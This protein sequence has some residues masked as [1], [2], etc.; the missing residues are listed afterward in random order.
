MQDTLSE[1]A[2]GATV[3]FPGREYTNLVLI[4]SHVT[5]EFNKRLPNI[6]RLRN[7]EYSDWLLIEP[8]PEVLS[9]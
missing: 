1:M 9:T 3:P 5:V 8:S 4:G 2:C 6:T 7:I